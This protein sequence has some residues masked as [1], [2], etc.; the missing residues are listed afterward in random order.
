MHA[1]AAA[2]LRVLEPVEEISRYWDSQAVAFDDGPDHG[3]HDPSVRAAWTSLLSAVLPPAPARVA[4]LGCGTGTLSV[5]LA[6]LS[7]DVS[8]VD[9][10]PKMIA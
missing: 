2:T 7:Y 6:E 10:S 8:G 9:L 1:G 5:L 3:L 4:D